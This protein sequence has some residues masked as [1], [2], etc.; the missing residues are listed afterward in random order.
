MVLTEADRARI[1]WI[2]EIKYPKNWEEL[3][4]QRQELMRRLGKTI[5]GETPARLTEKKL[6][7]TFIDDPSVFRGTLRK[8]FSVFRNKG[9]MRGG[10]Y[11]NIPFM[12][13]I[14]FL[15]AFRPS[16]GG[17]FQNMFLPL[18]CGN[19]AKSN[20]TFPTLTSL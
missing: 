15:S 3:S 14:T 7:Q 9:I 2:D 20:L 1:S 18:G 10:R 16:L 12:D 4:R 8:A 6:I 17:L 5:T 19:T 13:S 11:R